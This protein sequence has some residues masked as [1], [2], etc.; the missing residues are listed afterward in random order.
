MCCPLQVSYY[1]AGEECIGRLGE[2]EAR[3]AISRIAVTRQTTWVEWRERLD[4]TLQ[5]HFG[6]IFALTLDTS[7]IKFSAT[8]VLLTTS[9][10]MSLLSF[11]NSSQ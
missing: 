5:S 7:L 11:L 3:V 8:F 10:P 1:Q 4:S 9:H 2:I 6:F